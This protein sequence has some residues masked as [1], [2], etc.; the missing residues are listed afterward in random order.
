M[1]RSIEEWREEVERL[2]AELER[3]NARIG[4]LQSTFASERARFEDALHLRNRL[5]VDMA[6]LISSEARDYVRSVNT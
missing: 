5:V 6:R 4:E 1:S 2:T 3:A